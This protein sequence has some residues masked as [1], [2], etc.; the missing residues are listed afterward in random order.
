M[1]A[2]Q[3]KKAKAIYSE[4]VISRESNFCFGREEWERLIVK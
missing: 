1:K 4:L 2:N 3:M